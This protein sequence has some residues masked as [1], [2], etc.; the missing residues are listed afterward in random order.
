MAAAHEPIYDYGYSSFNCD[1]D[2]FQDAR[3]MVCASFQAAFECSTIRNIQLAREIAYYKPPAVGVAPRR[4]L[5]IRLSGTL[6][7]PRDPQV[8]LRRR[9]HERALCEQRKKVWFISWDNSFQVVKFSDELI[10]RERALFDRDTTCGGQ[11]RDRKVVSDKPP[12]RCRPRSSCGEDS[13]VEKERCGKI[14]RECFGMLEV[15]RFPR[16]SLTPSWR[17]KI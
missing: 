5:S 10:A 15:P 17:S 9:R 14:S 6:A 11:L 3:L 12:V 1:F 4:H 16:R 7:L 2:N 8:P 13:M